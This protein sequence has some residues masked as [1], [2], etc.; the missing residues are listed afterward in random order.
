MSF[1]ARYP[2]TCLDC[3]EPIRVGDQIEARFSKVARDFEGCRVRARR[4]PG[5]GPDAFRPGPGV[6][7]L[8]HREGRERGVRMSVTT[9]ERR[10]A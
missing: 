8:L 5:H 1:E 9:I 7:G 10:Q 4:V 3:E 2:G 6:P